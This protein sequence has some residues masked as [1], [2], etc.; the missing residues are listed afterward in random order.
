MS[1]KKLLLISTLIGGFTLGGYTSD[2]LAERG[3]LPRIVVPVLVLVT[4][5]VSMV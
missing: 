1:L 2:A 5:L 3:D 4:G